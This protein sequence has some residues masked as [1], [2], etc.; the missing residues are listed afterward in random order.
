MNRG[1]HESWTQKQTQ[2][3]HWELCTR[4]YLQREREQNKDNKSEAGARGTG[5]AHLEG[6]P[7]RPWSGP[8]ELCNRGRRYWQV[9]EQMSKEN[10]TKVLLAYMEGQ[11]EEL[12]GGFPWDN[13]ERGGMVPWV[14]KSIWAGRRTGRWSDWRMIS[15][16]RT[17]N[18]GGTRKPVLE[19]MNNRW[20]VQGGIVQRPVH[21]LN[22]KSRA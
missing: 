6:C 7:E 19:E 14:A 5:T 22:M 17:D 9:R 12:W 18:G 8:R 21:K 20:W 15:L 1:S 10:L 4:F 16:I 3:T 2:Y 13:P 11:A